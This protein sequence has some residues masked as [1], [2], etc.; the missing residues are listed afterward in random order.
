MAPPHV[1]GFFENFLVCKFFSWSLSHC[2]HKHIESQASRCL[3]NFTK[4]AA[5]NQKSYIIC[6][7]SQA[8]KSLSM[9]SRLTSYYYITFNRTM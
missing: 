9:N 3:S 1:P 8:G 5:D 7:L 2:P 4:K 6:G